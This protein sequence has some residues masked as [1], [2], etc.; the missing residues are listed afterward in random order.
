MKESSTKYKK[1][2]YDGKYL[3][4]KVTNVYHSA[5]TH[6]EDQVPHLHVQD[7]DI[8]INRCAEEYGNPCKNFCPADP[9]L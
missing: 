3:F 1:L 2:V 7:T 5:T 9:I 6:D 8:C 4:D